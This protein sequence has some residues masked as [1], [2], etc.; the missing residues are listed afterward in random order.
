[1]D[2]SYNNLWKVLEEKDMTK[3]ELKG[4][5]GMSSATIGKLGKNEN[6]ALKR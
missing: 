4:A 6:N 2:F 3:E 5:T 1:M